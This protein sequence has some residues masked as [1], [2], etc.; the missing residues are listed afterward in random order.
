MG[1]PRYNRGNL[2]SFEVPH[3]L[4]GGGASREVRVS[5]HSN[6]ALSRSQRDPLLVLVGF[7]ES[8]RVRL[9]TLVRLAQFGVAAVSPEIDYTKVTGISSLQADL[10]RATA[11]LPIAVAEDIREKHGGKPVEAI[12]HSL[13]GAQLGSAVRE[14]GELFGDIAMVNPLGMSIGEGETVDPT[15]GR[16]LWRFIRGT[17]L[18]HAPTTRGSHIAGPQIVAEL[19]RDQRADIFMPKLAAANELSIVAPVAAHA[20]DHAVTIVT[21][22]RDRLFPPSSIA[23]SIARHLGAE[24]VGHFISEDTTNLPP[25]M[26]G[27][28]GMHLLTVEGGKH[29]NLSFARG[30]KMLRLGVDALGRL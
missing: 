25:R 17:A 7:G 18:H 8:R 24:A 4:S 10:L 14:G 3:T 2:E 21:G 30:Q 5:V 16:F 6:I 22:E 26:I 13:G 15:S 23:A 20:A 11:E 27:E 19:W 28:Q 12:G 9:N 29:E 1:H